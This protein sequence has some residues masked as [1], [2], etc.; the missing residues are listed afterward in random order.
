MEKKCLFLIII[1]TMTLSSLFCMSCTSDDEDRN[2]DEIVPPDNP[3]HLP[4]GTYVE[5]EGYYYDGSYYGI[6]SDGNVWYLHSSYQAITN[7][8][9]PEKVVLM[10]KTYTVTHMMDHALSGSKQLTTVNL[11][12]TITYLGESVFT[13]CD[14]LTNINLPEGITT[15]R[16]YTFHGC[17]SLKS[18]ALP[19]SL[20]TISNYAFQ[21]CEQLSSI[22][23][24][25]SLTSIGQEAFRDCNGLD[26]VIIPEG[27]TYVGLD[28]FR[29]CKN[30]TS[31]SI[32][33]SM[34]S[35]LTPFTGCDAITSVNISCWFVAGFGNKV[36]NV[37]LNEGVTTI[38]GNAFKDCK[39]L[40]FVEFPSTIFEIGPNS[41]QGC[42]SLTS[43]VFPENFCWIY[44]RAFYDCHNL[45]SVTCLGA[46]PPSFP[47]VSGYPAF[48]PE[49]QEN[50]ILYVPSALVD[51]YKSANG[52]RDF[53]NI[54]GI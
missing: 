23:F 54:V 31:I 27:V 15:I 51:T 46:T 1:A 10:G 17:K 39:N 6:D 49:T 22:T 11:P 28:A 48:D 16:L 12:C 45:L 24:P 37:V 30:L 3:N 4:N 14:N 7:V 40:H 52:W 13:G 18:I 25:P 8:T 38:N 34:R 43:I 36:T 32:P 21:G 33:S 29:D 35:Y 19:Q 47:D 9:I 50:G 53:K 41:F 5:G 44:D 20:T 42:T 2:N 26:T